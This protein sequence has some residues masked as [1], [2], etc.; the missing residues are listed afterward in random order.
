LRAPV[1]W[2][3]CFVTCAVL[4]PCCWFAT[5]AVPLLVSQG[6]GTAVSSQRRSLGRD[7]NV[8]IGAVGVASSDLS[9]L[10][11]ATSVGSVTCGVPKGPRASLRNSIKAGPS[12]LGSDG[13]GA[14]A[15]PPPAGTGM[16]RN[17][18]SAVVKTEPP[19][20]AAPPTKVPGKGVAR[21]THLYI[22]HGLGCPLIHGRVVFRPQ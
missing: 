12:P 6:A 17:R 10:P 1:W 18:M 21:R 5:H 8:F 11:Q 19:L 22:F 7:E 20:R 13:N 15:V 16:R 4:T 14:A 2:R 9:T 3:R